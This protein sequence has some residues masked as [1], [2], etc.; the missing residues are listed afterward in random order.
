MKKADN[1]NPG[2]WLV[3]NKLTNQSKINEIKVVN[4]V[5]KVDVRQIFTNIGIDLDEELAEEEPMIEY[6]SDEWMAIL[7]AITG[8]DPYEDNVDFDEE[9]K[10]AIQMF[11]EEA[12]KLGFEFV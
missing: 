1:F 3:E 12:E 5:P 10:A 2:Q 4:P 11:V 9:E 8:K 6:G 7:E